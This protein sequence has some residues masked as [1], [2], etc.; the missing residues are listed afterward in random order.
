MQEA[1]SV[2]NPNVDLSLIADVIQDVMSDRD[3]RMDELRDILFSL[4][5][6]INAPSQVE[7]SKNDNLIES[8]R[9]SRM[10]CE[11]EAQTTGQMHLQRMLTEEPDY[12]LLCKIVEQA[13]SFFD[14][15]E[16]VN[17]TEI[18]DTEFRNDLDYYTPPLRYQVLAG[19]F[20]E[21]LKIH[22]EVLTA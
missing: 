18:S 8:L 21:A 3:R 4:Y 20:S 17:L 2:I 11:A 12:D 14:D 7:F 10:N 5:Q 9:Q 22:K 6:Y 16:S 15:A 19:F 1:T 13:E